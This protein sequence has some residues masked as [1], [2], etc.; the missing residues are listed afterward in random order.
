MK[1]ADKVFGTIMVALLAI[2]GFVLGFTA[3]DRTVTEAWCQAKFAVAQT[4]ADSL[5]VVRDTLPRG[6]TIAG[7]D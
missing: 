1:T 7:G 4:A 2:L 6:C 5:A 3:A